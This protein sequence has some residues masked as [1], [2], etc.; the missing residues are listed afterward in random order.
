MSASGWL[1]KPQTAN[2]SAATELSRAGFPIFAALVYR[3]E[4]SGRWQKRPLVAQRQTV[5]STDAEQL[6]IWWRSYPTAVPGLELGR[7]DLVV[8]DADRH[9]GPEGVAAFQALVAERV[10]PA[11]P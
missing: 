2:L 1:S 10:L 5:A 4:G 3:K 6:Q 11:G 8:I 7:A 9:G